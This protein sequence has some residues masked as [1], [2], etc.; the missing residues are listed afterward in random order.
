MELEIIMLN[1]ISYTQKYKYHMFYLIWE[2]YIEK[3]SMNADGRLFEK[4]KGP[5][6]GRSTDGNWGQ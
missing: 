6:R 1:E 5:E 4:R 3:K 2:I